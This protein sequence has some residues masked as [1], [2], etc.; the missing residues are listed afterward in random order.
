MRRCLVVGACIEFT[1]LDLEAFSILG[2]ACSGRWQDDPAPVARS[3]K[4]MEA[5]SGDR[6][7]AALFWNLLI[8]SVAAGSKVNLSALRC[9]SM[10]T[11]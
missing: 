8:P 3:T 9:F 1:A 5:S 4:R 11:I 10:A 7:P 2:A 6:A